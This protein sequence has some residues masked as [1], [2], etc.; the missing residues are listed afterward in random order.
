M[1]D[2]LLGHSRFAVGAFYLGFALTGFFG[3]SDEHS[4]EH[5]LAA[6]IYC[7][8]L[9]MWCVVDSMRRRA[10]FPYALWWYCSSPLVLPITVV[11]LL[12]TRG[13][14]AI[15]KIFQHLALAT[16]VGISFAVLGVI[17]L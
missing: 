8:A 11:Y 3:V 1:G 12:R 14:S 13:R 4:L 17:W 15:A 9:L 2:P 16:L 10:S 7:S 6:W 5:W